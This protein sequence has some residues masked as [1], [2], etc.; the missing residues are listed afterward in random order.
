[1]EISISSFQDHTIV[2]VE[3]DIEYNNVGKLKK[4]INSM[5]E[6]DINSLLLNMKEVKYIDS[7]GIGLLAT[8]QKKMRTKKAK[9]AIYNVSPDIRDMLRISTIDS[10]L[11]IHNSLEEAG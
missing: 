10:L 6:E 1:M 3:G 9:F 2:S 4:T 5:I 7:M 11:T 8:T